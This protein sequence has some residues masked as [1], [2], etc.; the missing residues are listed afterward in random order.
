[1]DMGSETGATTTM[2]SAIRLPEFRPQTFALNLPGE[3]FEYHPPHPSFYPNAQLEEP[4]KFLEYTK[5]RELEYPGH[6][7]FS[8]DAEYIGFEYPEHE[9]FSQDTEYSGF[10]HPN[11]ES[12]SQDTEYSGFEHPKYESFS[13]DAEYS[14]FDYPEN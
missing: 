10:E 7:S 4:G 12:F 6:E 3:Y 5:H 11:H 1:M 2:T 13:Q 14:V 8:Q 9:S